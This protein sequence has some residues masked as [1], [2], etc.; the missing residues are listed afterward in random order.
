M[1]SSGSNSASRSSEFPVAGVAPAA[2]FAIPSRGLP[3]VLLDVPS[4]GASGSAQST[5][6]GSPWSTP[7]TPFSPAFPFDPQTPQLGHSSEDENNSNQGCG[8]QTDLIAPS[9]GTLATSVTDPRSILSST[10]F[11]LVL[12]RHDTL[13][14]WLRATHRSDQTFVGGS[15]YRHLEVSHDGNGTLLGS[16]SVTPHG[17]KTQLDW[18]TRNGACLEQ[19]RVVDLHGELPF[20]SLVFFTN[21]LPNLETVRLFPDDAGR[22]IDKCPTVTKNLVIVGEPKVPRKDP[23]ESCIPMATPLLRVVIHV[24]AFSNANSLWYHQL[25]FPYGAEE[26]VIVF[27]GWKRPYKPKTRPRSCSSTQSKSH[28]AR[29]RFQNLHYAVEHII[30]KFL[31]HSGIETGGIRCTIVDLDTV[32]PEWFGLPH[33]AAVARWLHEEVRDSLNTRRWEGV[34]EEAISLLSFKSDAQW[35]EEL[36]VEQDGS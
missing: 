9:S 24:D 33:D 6:S 5:T 22:C 25:L 1:C 7:V 23:G 35:R 30:T 20:H 36:L 31:G 29:E 4:L 34:A 27:T 10:H 11:D 14:S 13:L 8:S 21:R 26:I 16:L 18:A 17:G 2:T 28:A 12:R 32:D 3:P 15:V 19:T